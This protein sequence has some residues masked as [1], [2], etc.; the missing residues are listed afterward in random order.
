MEGTQIARTLKTKWMITRMNPAA[1]THSPLRIDKK[2]YTRTSR[3]CCCAC[4]QYRTTV[5]NGRATHHSSSGYT[6]DVNDASHNVERAQHDVLR[7]ELGLA[8][9]VHGLG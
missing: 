2:E 3:I 8:I 7:R 4:N 1:T 9:C 6:K 5:E